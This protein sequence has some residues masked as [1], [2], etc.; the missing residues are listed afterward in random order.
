MRRLL[1][2][3]ACALMV[4]GVTGTAA[5]GSGSDSSG[6][7]RYTSTC[8]AGL[9]RFTNTSDPTS[10][11]NGVIEFRTA[12]AT[13]TLGPGESGVLDP[14]AVSPDTAWDVVFFDL[15]EPYVFDSGTF[16]VCEPAARRRRCR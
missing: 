3:V 2:L 7:H 8:E 16:R 12:G 1:L 6:T 14:G 4:V 13:L 15:G 9:P 10:T 5:A 11:G